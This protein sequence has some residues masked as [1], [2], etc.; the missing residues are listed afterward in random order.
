MRQERKNINRREFMKLSAVGAGCALTLRSGQG[1]PA[2]A[3]SVEDSI[4]ARLKIFDSKLPVGLYGRVLQVGDLIPPGL[5]PQSNL[6]PLPSARVSERLQRG[7]RGLL[8]GQPWTAL[9]SPADTVAIKINGLASGHLSPRIELIEAVIQGVKSAGVPAGN[10]IIWDRTSRELERCGLSLQ[11]SETEVRVYGTDALT[12]G[13]Y[14]KKIESFGSVGSLPSRILTDYATAMI[15]IG[16]LKDH[17]LS[18]VSAGMK[19]LY[20]VIHNPNR[21]HDNRCDPYLADLLAL[22]T[23]RRTLRLTIIDAI[24]AQAEGGPAFSLD[25]IWPNNSLLLSVDPV[26]CDQ[27]AASIIDR[28]RSRR[29]LPSLAEDGRDPTWLTTAAN[30]G[31]GRCRDLDVREL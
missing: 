11:R 29:G 7:M 21:Y 23:V 24:L 12:G 22:P 30:L 2:A 28:E 19:N 16:V 18:G 10:I 31:L 15:N 8:G 4:N 26:A 17:D 3:A 1:N 6:N 27:V 20:G 9:F 25:W 14:A 5:K 13:G